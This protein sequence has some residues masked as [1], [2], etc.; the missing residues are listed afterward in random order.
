[1]VYLRLENYLMVSLHQMDLF[2]VKLL[3]F[4]LSGISKSE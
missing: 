1:M 2:G 4:F 3:F